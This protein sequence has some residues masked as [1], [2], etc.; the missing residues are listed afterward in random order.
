M[1]RRPQTRTVCQL[2]H[3][4][5][6]Q[7]IFSPPRAF[8]PAMGF[9][10]LVKKTTFGRLVQNKQQQG[11][12]CRS[13]LQEGKNTEASLSLLTEA[14][15]LLLRGVFSVAASFTAICLSIHAPKSPTQR[16]PDVF[17]CLFPMKNSWLQRPGWWKQQSLSAC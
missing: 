13:L 7:S 4:H 1:W 3:C 2:C 16:E 15:K 6:W 12:L 11:Q 5:R 9:R 14:T 8:L 10:E 17:F